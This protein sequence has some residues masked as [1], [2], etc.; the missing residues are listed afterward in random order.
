MNLIRQSLLNPSAQALDALASEIWGVIQETE[1][2]PEVVL[3]TSG[4][5][6]GLRQALARQ[7][8]ATLQPDLLFMPR[9]QGLTEWLLETP[10]LR[11]LPATKTDLQRIIDVYQML[12]ERADLRKMLVGQSEA[13]RWQLA[14][15]IVTSCDLLSDACLNEA[16][17]PSEDSLRLVIDEVY[18]GLAKQAL[19]LEVDL[20]LSFWRFMTTP[21][22]WPVRLRYAMRYRANHHAGSTIFIRSG[23]GSK[24]FMQSYRSMLESIAQR[25]PVMEVVYDYSA[26]ALWE[27]CLRDRDQDGLTQ[28]HHAQNVQHNREQFFKETAQRQIV[29]ARNFEQAAGLAV[30]RLQEY[31]LAGHHELALV[32]QDRLVARRARA[33]LARL[34]ST[35]RVEDETGWKLS[36]TRTAA[37]LMAWLNMARMAQQGPKTI[38]LI[39]FLNNPYIDWS[40]WGLSVEEAQLALEFFEDECLR[41]DVKLGWAPMFAA[42]MRAQVDQDQ[43]IWKILQGIEK[44]LKNWCA[45]PRRTGAQWYALWHEQWQQMGLLQAYEKDA[46]GHQ[47]LDQLSELG[48]LLTQPLSLAEFLGLVSNRCEEGSYVEEPGIAEF[49]VRMIPLSAA[50]LRRFD[51]WV[52]VGCD[53]SHLP[54]INEAPMFFSNRLRQLIGAKT[55]EDEFAQQARDLN[56]LMISHPTWTMLWQAK[57]AAGEDWQPAP[58][59]QRLYK[60]RLAE[61]DR[62]A[63]LEWVPIS[64]MP[65]GMASAHM[66]ND[67]LIPES[68]SPSAYRLLRECPY[69]YFVEKILRL[70]NR[71]DLDQEVD[72]SVVGQVLHQILRDFYHSLKTQPIQ[73]VDRQS[74]L[75]E[76]LKQFSEDAFAPLLSA[77]GRWLATWIAWR[78]Q[79]PSWIS[80]QLAREAEGWQFLD[81]ER[82]VE[83]S[84]PH[85]KGSIRVHGF[86]DRIDE[87]QAHELSVLDYKFSKSGN[88]K[89]RQKYFRDDPQLA[90]YGLALACDP[91][92]S[93]K[94]VH[95]AAW[96]SLKEATGAIPVAE[97]RSA[98]DE[99][100]MQL[101]ADINAVVEG[102]QLLAHAP[103]SICQYCEARGVCRKGMWS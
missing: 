96:V 56:E 89:N 16:L 61:L 68:I 94:P 22:D 40:L 99:T 18:S 51:A 97:W 42:L 78:N 3:W 29:K 44:Y 11:D 60:E 81:A 57:G 74:L 37:T 58:W 64:P 10:Q 25:H 72:L 30:Q 1:S 2:T 83:F 50:R 7:R 36:T 17:E 82:Y 15:S 46:A 43:P 14:Q 9:V 45:A 47:L 62:S 69:R 19:G 101:Q 53:Q 100:Y 91:S 31:M 54:S 98:M 24:G 63:S 86:I 92:L 65:Q 48:D 67:A 80:W 49:T 71:G 79:I 73:R 13:A 8:P 93:E 12:A 85:S 20:L 87:N 41:Q 77:D 59:L 21:S 102:G 84:L 32:A 34:G 70:K 38:D 103:D 52:M 76:R 88:I 6:M 55:I 26:I 35:V 75:I 28:G 33:L 23:L 4:P 39:D 95:E 90:I 66:V 27:E 5:A